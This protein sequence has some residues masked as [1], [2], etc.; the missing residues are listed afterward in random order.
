MI[1]KQPYKTPEGF[2]DLWMSGDE[3]GLTGLWFEGA[4]NAAGHADDRILRAGSLPAFEQTRRWLDRYFAGG[5]PD[6]L[7]AMSI[8]GVTPFRREVLDE[9]LAIPYGRTVSYG[10]IAGRIAAR[11][12][13]ANMSAQAVGGAVGWNPIGIL[14][15]CHRVIGAD[16][17]LTG[18]GG[19]M[20]NKIALLAL[21]RAS[22]EA[23]DKGRESQN[24]HPALRPFDNGV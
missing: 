24:R 7:P 6:F 2:D 21:E 17:S 11:R 15:P 16:G 13:M 14:I 9:M 8:R 18:Y 12:G 20:H 10:A 23:P 19:G 5:Q 22:A 3:E 1:Y 4:V